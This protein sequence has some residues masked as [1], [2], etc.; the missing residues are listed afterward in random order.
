MKKTVLR[1]IYVG[2]DGDQAVTVQLQYV[3][4]VD[5][6]DIVIPDTLLDH[7]R[8]DLATATPEQKAALKSALG[9]L[10]ARQ[11]EKLSQLKAELAEAR[12]EAESLNHLRDELAATQKALAQAQAELHV[13]QQETGILGDMGI[14][15]THHSGGN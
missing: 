13:I 10:G 1:S 2:F 5:I 15:T 12:Q 3:E 4:R 11:T 14:D 6:P 9:T 7:V 8:F